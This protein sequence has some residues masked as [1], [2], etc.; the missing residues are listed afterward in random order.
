[1]MEKTRKIASASD[2]A[3]QAANTKPFLRPRI[4]G[5]PDI[6]E[7]SVV[8]NGQRWPSS[9]EPVDEKTAIFALQHG[10]N[11]EARRII[12]RYLRETETRS[13]RVLGYLA[14]M[15]DPPEDCSYPFIFQFKKHSD[16]VHKLNRYA[17]IGLH[18]RALHDQRGGALKDAIYQTKMDLGVSV[19]DIYR[20]LDV[21]P[22]KIVGGKSPKA[23]KGRTKIVDW[24]SDEASDEEFSRGFDK[25]LERQASRERAK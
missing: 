20:G 6:E 16:K 9:E 5:D 3:R 4:K 24:R 2:R 7:V 25:M 13:L 21:I 12:G 18:C 10:T 11:P 22:G 23:S 8:H 1:M 15:I 14:D 17:E 19:R